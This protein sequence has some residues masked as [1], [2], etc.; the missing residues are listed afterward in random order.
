MD[1]A[2]TGHALAITTSMASGIRQAFGTMTMVLHVSRDGIHAAR[3][4]GGGG[5]QRRPRRSRLSSSAFLLDLMGRLF[6]KER[7]AMLDRLQQ[8]SSVLHRI[9]R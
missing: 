9:G 7:D 1:P 6:P 5:V 3:L 4:A 8:H 2:R